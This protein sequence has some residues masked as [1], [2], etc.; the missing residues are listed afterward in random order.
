[1]NEKMN[2]RLA[3]AIHYLIHL[4]QEKDWPLG[5][6]KLAK[7][8]VLSEVASMGYRPRLLTGIK[9]IKAPNGPIPRQ[10]DEHLES[11][12]RAGKIRISKG[13][14]QFDSTSYASLS[15]PDLSGFDPQELEILARIGEDCCNN[16]TATA[17]KDLTHNDSWQVT[18]MGDEIPLAAYL[19][20]KYVRST[21]EQ[22]EKSRQELRAMGYEF[23]L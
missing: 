6:V 17:L 5:A 16:Y 12:E 11:L 2:D 20:H 10:F 22:L 3:Q 8:L 1:M 13:E 9:I 7:S 23:P 18:D 14:Q 4:A 15:P 19:P 21:P